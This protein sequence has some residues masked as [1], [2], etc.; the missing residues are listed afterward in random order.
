MTS[1]SLIPTWLHTLSYP[2]SKSHN[3]SLNPSYYATSPDTLLTTSTPTSFHLGTGASIFSSLQPALEGTNRELILVTC[4]WAPSPS[5]DT[6]NRILL[7]LSKKGLR[8]RR[9]IRVRIYFSSVS[10]WQKLMAFLYHPGGRASYP[11]ETWKSRLGLP[12]PA[13]LKGLDLKITS[14]FVAPFCVMHPKFFVVDRKEVWVPS[15]NVSWEEWFEG[16]IGLRGEVVGSFLRLWREFWV[17]EED[18][19]DDWEIAGEND[20]EPATS[21]EAGVEQDESPFSDDGTVVRY[22][23]RTTSATQS[24]SL[25]LATSKIPT[26]FLPSPHTRNP[27]F[28]PFPWQ[29]PAPAPPTPL[30]TF[31]LA[32]IAAATKTIYIQTPNLTSPPLLAALL[33]KLQTSPQVKVHIVT[34]ARLMVLEQLVTAGTTTGRCVAALISRYRS[35]Q[36]ASTLS[37]RTPSMRDLE[38]QHIRPG[39]LEIDFYEPLPRLPSP[40]AGGTAAEP[41][42]SHLKCTIIDS[43]IL[44]LGSGNMDRASWYTSQELGVAFF[45]AELANTVEC[46][47][48]R[49]L[50]G[51]RRCVFDSERDGLGG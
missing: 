21:I 24:I 37:S 12:E 35:L 22:T 16:C 36:L 19:E 39:G 5:L 50:Q 9:R 32:A 8:N 26:I 27:L 25:S 51:R 2:S 14:L 41:V 11:P 44:V 29:D 3:L 49:A 15:C 30:N 33:A 28:R 18:C 38:A 23:E 7:Y 17:D 1:P 13:E 34:S 20:A 46:A 40:I 10:I 48:G 43:E 47:L 42:Q 45:S 6:L 31:L 4:F